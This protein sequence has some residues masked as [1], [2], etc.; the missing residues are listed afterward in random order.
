MKIHLAIVS[1]F[2]IANLCEGTARASATSVNEA[3]NSSD[4]DA[5][6]ASDRRE[7]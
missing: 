6:N 1:L 4:D 7:M 3:G 5:R 2:A